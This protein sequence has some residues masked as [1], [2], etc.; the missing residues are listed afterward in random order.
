MLLC[1]E[2]EKFDHLTVSLSVILQTNRSIFL[3]ILG[4]HTHGEE[5]RGQRT[6]PQ[7]I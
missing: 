6:N 3:I 1:K 7:K 4:K 2:K 5:G